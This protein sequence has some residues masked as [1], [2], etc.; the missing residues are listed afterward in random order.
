MIDEEILTELGVEITGGNEREIQ[1]FCPVHHLVKGRGQEKPKWY[2][3]RDTGA[4]L[5]FSC[6]QAGGLQY[7]VELL[8]GDIEIIEQVD[9][10]VLANT[11]R[12]A[13]LEQEVVEEE[14]A[15][16]VYVSEYGFSKHPLPHR[17]IRE[18]R[19]VTLE[20]CETHNVRWNKEDR[21]FLIPL[22]TI[23]DNTLIGWQE[24]SKGYFMNVPET[25]PKRLCLFGY[26]QFIGSRMIVVESPLDVVRLTSHGFVG[27]VAVMGSFVSNEQIQGIKD[28]G[29]G[30]VVLA[31]DDDEAGDS[32]GDTVF[33]R[34][35]GLDI[36][37]RR[38][39]YP[40][41]NRRKNGSH[42]FGKDPGELSIE[43]LTSGL[44]RQRLTL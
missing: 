9:A 40:M 6:H 12:R 18:I 31:F 44:E 32:A 21:C 25:V 20:A 24:K 41:G 10:K 15:P 17:A 36:R 14:K 28:A 16:E 39:R 11:A 22:Y 7:L 2:M 23:K 13:K 30:E 1:A 37:V 4:W 5:C 42:R 3:N 26:Q 19:D 33:E 8:D 29:V 38:F 43:H 34:L 27:S 35:S